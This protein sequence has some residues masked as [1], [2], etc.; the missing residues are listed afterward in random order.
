MTATPHNGKEEDFQLYLSLL[1]SDRFYGRFRD[2]VHRV[3]A[4]DMMRRMIKEHLVK[5]DGTPLF[6]E[7]RAYTVNYSLSE[8]EAQLYG[9]VTEYV[10]LEMGRAEQL[11]DNRRKGN[12]GF[13]LTTLQRRL[14]S[15]PEAIYQSLRRRKERLE[16][17][18]REEKLL[19][20]GQSTLSQRFQSHINLPE[21]DDD[22][23]AEEQEKIEEEVVDLASAAQTIN[24]LE[25]EIETLKVLEL[26]ALQVVHSG[27]DRK[28]DELSRLLQHNAEMRD[29]SG[30]QRK[31]II[32]S[33]H[34]D[35]LNYLHQKISN[36]VGRPEA[37][38]TI[39][40]GT[41]REDRRKTQ[42]NFRSD[43]TVQVLIATDAAGEGVNLQNANLMVN[44]DLPWNPNRLEQRFGRIHRIGQTEVCHLWN[45]VAN[46]TREGEVYCRLLDK[47]QSANAA[48]NGRVFDV[49][50]EVFEET[51]LKDLLVEAIRYGEMPDVRARLTT[52][53]DHCLDHENIQKLLERNALSQEAMT[54]ERLFSVKAEMDKAEARRLQPYFVKAFFEKAFSMFEGTLHKRELNR[55]EVTHVP[56]VIRERDRIMTGR[57]RRENEPVLK[58]Y[59]RICF[60][61]KAIRPLDR[62]GLAPAVLVHPG[63]PLMISLTD[64]ILERHTNLMRQGA[65][66]ADPSDPGDQPWLLYLLAHRVK[67]STDRTISERIQFIRVDRDK[68][69]T[70]AGWAPHLDLEPISADDRTALAPYINAPWITA[71]LEQQAIAMATQNLVPSH[72]SEVRDRRIQHINK[73]LNA[74]HERLTKEIAFWTDRWLKLRNDK[75]AGKDI[76]GKDQTAHRTIVEL[77]Q[78]L[79]SRKEALNRERDIRN[80]TPV[81]LGGALVIPGGLISRI[82]GDAPSDLADALF[83]ADAAARAR[84]EKI[85][86]KAVMDAE[87]ARGC[88]VVDVSAEKCGWDITSYPPSVNGLQP[89][90]RH[91]E[92]KGRIQ[93]AATITVTRNEMLYAFNQGDKF[94]LAIVMVQDDGS[95]NG[96]YYIRTP[97]KSE[98]GWGVASINFEIQSLLGRAESNTND[99]NGRCPQ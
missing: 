33:E 74:V 83:A 24:E 9:D 38:V 15:S 22:L 50:G 6:P 39:H 12:V 14:A 52:T 58:R 69:A 10:R 37:V 1:D 70:F 66:L 17:K 48:L 62:P 85:A 80:S 95:F 19:A 72:F 61:K 7:R 5:F 56:A 82:K 8:P 89:L 57:N 3:D 71:D 26:Q 86:M 93:G 13:A 88:T 46:E 35:T 16:N 41:N 55:F 63:H 64:L 51:S 98:P 53:V 59:E 94:L 18:L 42:A 99:I 67:D 75:D 11:A 32:F 27:T 25:I 47:L 76:R 31:L 92:V 90:P 20:R 30:N 4:S 60:E 91:I 34:K 54:T 23:N 77:Q 40:G 87:I 2:G 28:W 21:D 84:I 81:V 78:R 43:P 97:F 79:E 49:L 65:V 29:I 36:L 73:T 45:L 44:Y 68:S 96:P